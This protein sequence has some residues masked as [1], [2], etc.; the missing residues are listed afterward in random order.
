MQ[1]QKKH[2]KVNGILLILL[3]LLFSVQAN[4]Q[5][6]QPIALQPFGT[7]DHQLHQQ[8]VN[9]IKK[10]FCKVEVDIPDCHPPAKIRLL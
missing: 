7:I 3:V 2:F 5:W 8:V 9:S 6:K 10:T 4:S 1:T